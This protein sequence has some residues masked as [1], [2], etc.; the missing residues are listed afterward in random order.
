MPNSVIEDNNINLN[1]NSWIGK[2]LALCGMRIVETVTI[3]YE[4]VF[5]KDINLSHH[6]GCPIGLCLKYR[7]RSV[8]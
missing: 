4:L 8:F 5:I 7:D 3:F 2:T 1:D 6:N